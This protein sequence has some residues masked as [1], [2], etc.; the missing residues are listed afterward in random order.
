M[1]AR[2]TIYINENPDWILAGVYSECI[3]GTDFSKRKEFKR[4]I[5]DAKA[6]KIDGVRSPSTGCSPMKN[7]QAWRFYRKSMWQTH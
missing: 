2:T 3:S 7:M 6:G 1:G 5:K 4:M